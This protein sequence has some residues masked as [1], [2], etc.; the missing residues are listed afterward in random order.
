M[1][2]YQDGADFYREVDFDSEESGYLWSA[3]EGV[4][5]SDHDIDG[6]QEARRMFV[7]WCVENGFDPH[8]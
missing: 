7:T 2:V 8:F 4:V 3:P 1:N 5:R 6:A